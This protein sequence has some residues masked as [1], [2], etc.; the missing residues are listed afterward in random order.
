VKAQPAVV[1]KAESKN[2]EKKWVVVNAPV[3]AQQ[4]TVL[5]A[6]MDFPSDPLGGREEVPGMTRDEVARVKA[7]Y[8][9]HVWRF[10]EKQ[11]RPFEFAKFDRTAGR[12]RHEHFI[13][14]VVPEPPVMSDFPP[15]PPRA[16]P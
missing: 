2:F 3:K 1:A 16:N 14:V 9:K 8:Q 5:M 15:A 7:E 10:K 13:R 11:A 6:K 4:P 12:A